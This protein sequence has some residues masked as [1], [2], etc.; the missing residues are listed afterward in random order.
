ME[1]TPK[2]QVVGGA[3]ITVGASIVTHRTLL[4]IILP[5][6]LRKEP[7]VTR[8]E[9]WDNVVNQKLSCLDKASNL[10]EGELTLDWEKRSDLVYAPEQRKTPRILDDEEINE[11]D[12]KVT[13]VADRVPKPPGWLKRK[14]TRTTTVYQNRPKGSK[15]V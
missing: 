15:K 9:N 10:P 6:A 4:L 13:E 12:P 14:K 7:H 8:A 3:E 11:T 5:T 2:D 1:D